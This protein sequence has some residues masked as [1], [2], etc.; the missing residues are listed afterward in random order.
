MAKNK[1]RI[2]FTAL[3][4]SLLA[5]TALPA[6]AWSWMDYQENFS[7]KSNCQARGQ[8]LVKNV[9]D[10]GAFECRYNSKSRT[11]RLWVLRDDEF[12][13]RTALSATR[14]SITAP[15]GCGGSV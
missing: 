8:W 9:V 12:G 3:L 6:Q 10:L 14:K 7:L 4:V 13:C 1:I 2:A 5:L 15:Q 11:Y